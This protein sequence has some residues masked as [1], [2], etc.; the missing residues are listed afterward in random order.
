MKHIETLRKNWI[1]SRTPPSPPWRHLEGHRHW[2][3]GCETSIP[4]TQNPRNWD[5]LW[6]LMISYD[7]LIWRYFK[8]FKI[9]NQF[10]RYFIICSTN[11]TSMDTL[12]TQKTRESSILTFQIPGIGASVA[13]PNWKPPSGNAKKV[14]L[15]V[16]KKKTDDLKYVNIDWPT[17]TYI[18]HH[19]TTKW[20]IDLPP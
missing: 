14:K 8:N 10:W 5:I 12:P 13:C 9:M 19:F 17:F 2:A 6:Y 18:L 20:A 1:F 11:S 3:L 4:E 7:I 15:L 16:S